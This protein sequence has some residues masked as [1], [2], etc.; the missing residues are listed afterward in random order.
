MS[1]PSMDESL[2][3]GML[4]NGSF[5]ADPSDPSTG[6]G[7]NTPDE[8]IEREGEPDLGPGDDDRVEP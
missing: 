1:D 5:G 7:D 3:T 2:L 8:D 4:P 6:Q